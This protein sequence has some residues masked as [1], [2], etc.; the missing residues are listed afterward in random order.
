MDGDSTTETTFGSFCGETTE[1][2]Q[3]EPG[4]AVIFWVGRADVAILDGCAPGIATQGTLDVVF[5]NMP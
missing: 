1:P 3:I 4:A 2:I 5:S